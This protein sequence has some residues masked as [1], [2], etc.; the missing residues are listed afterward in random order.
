VCTVTVCRANG[1]YSNCVEGECSARITCNVTDD[2]VLH[3]I[4][5]LVQSIPL[6]LREIKSAGM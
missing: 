3:R 5:T 6:C 4:Q 2:S 1:V